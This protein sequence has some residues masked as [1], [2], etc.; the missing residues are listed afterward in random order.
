M[1]LRIQQLTDLIQRFQKTSSP[2][3]ANLV[4]KCIAKIRL[5]MNESNTEEGD[6]EVFES[7]VEQFEEMRNDVNSET[8]ILNPSKKFL[9]CMLTFR[10][11]LFDIKTRLEYDNPSVAIQ[12]G[13]DLNEYVKTIIE[14]LDIELTQVAALSSNGDINYI[15][16]QLAH[17]YTSF[18]TN[19]LAESFQFGKDILSYFEEIYKNSYQVQYE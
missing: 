12:D 10:G 1:I 11:L 3:T 15:Q 17:L 4:E 2:A 8:D 7:I 6:Q 14:K 5:E 9:Q 19:R 18:S 16:Q 13:L